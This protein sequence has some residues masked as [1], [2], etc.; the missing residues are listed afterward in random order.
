MG[1]V[2]CRNIRIYVTDANYGFM[3]WHKGINVVPTL[4]SDELGIPEKGLVAVAAEL[5][6]LSDND[7]EGEAMY[8]HL[9]TKK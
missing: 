4:K 1:K 5:A 8:S 3:R 9:L 7:K 6:S 2:L